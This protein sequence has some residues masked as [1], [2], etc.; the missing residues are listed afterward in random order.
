MVYFTYDYS[1]KRRHF[2]T[3]IYHFTDFHSAPMFAI[4]TDAVEGS[5]P[6]GRVAV[7]KTV[8]DQILSGFEPY[9]I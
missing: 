9:L 1:P 8:D 4:L 2:A 3:L 7:S 5:S 6:G